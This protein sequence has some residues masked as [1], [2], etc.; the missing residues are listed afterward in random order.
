MSS[1]LLAKSLKQLYEC[2]LSY[3]FMG[4]EVPRD[5]IWRANQIRLGT[6]KASVLSIAIFGL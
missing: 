3:Y 5:V 2:S 6:V 1:K 4:R